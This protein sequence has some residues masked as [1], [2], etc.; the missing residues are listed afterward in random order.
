MHFL[1]LEVSVT[2]T[3]PKHSMIL[4]Y[5]NLFGLSPSVFFFFFQ[6][7][8]VITVGSGCQKGVRVH[9]AN[10]A[11]LWT[12][13]LWLSAMPEILGHFQFLGHFNIY[14]LTLK[15]FKRFERFRSTVVWLWVCIIFLIHCYHTVTVYIKDFSR[16]MRHVD[17]SSRAGKHAT[18]YTLDM[19]LVACLSR[20]ASVRFCFFLF[21][22]RCIDVGSYSAC[23]RVCVWR[24][25]VWLTVEGLFRPAKLRGS[26]CERGCC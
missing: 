19:R 4:L 6:L 7:C 17:W 1:I 2:G 18:Y 25:A 20:L 10:R 15:A 12:L 26:E 11:Y 5:M 24:Q 9:L 22:Y 3:P 16:L 14:R 23:V 8:S 21:F 13:P